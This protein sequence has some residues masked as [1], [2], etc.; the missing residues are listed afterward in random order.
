MANFIVER[1][2]IR[3]SGVLDGP[4]ASQLADAIGEG[5]F[6]VLDFSEVTSVNFAALRALLRCRQSGRRF[7]VINALPEVAEKKYSNK[8]H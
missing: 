7:F 5:L 3:V 2:N 8:Q 1:N 6:Y 4:A